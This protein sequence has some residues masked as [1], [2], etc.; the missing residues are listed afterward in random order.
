MLGFGAAGYIAKKAEDDPKFSAA[1]EDLDQL[2]SRKQSYLDDIASMAGGGAAAIGLGK[3][4]AKKLP[5]KLA[6]LY[7]PASAAGGGAAYEVFHSKEGEELESA[8]EGAGYGLAGYGAFAGLGKGIGA[9]TKKKSIDDILDEAD[10]QPSKLS[11]S[12]DRGLGAISTRLGNISPDLKF[13]LREF[14][15]ASAIKA[16]D[17]N[18]QV[19]PF[20]QGVKKIPSEVKLRFDQHLFNGDFEEASKILRKVDA[21]AETAFR[22]RV[23]P[24]L[25]DLGDKL[26][27]AGHTFEKLDN[28]FPRI[29]KDYDEFRKSIGAEQRGVITKELADYAAKKKISISDITP[30]E[31]TQIINMTLR[32]YQQVPGSKLRFVKKREVKQIGDD[33]MD[34][35]ISPEESLLRYIKGSV[36]DLEKRRFFG[37]SS[38]TD[39]DGMFDTSGSIGQLVDEAMMRGRI[40]PGRER[41]VKDMLEARFMGEFGAPN[42]FFNTVR[43]LGYMGT[44][45]NPVSTITQFGD[46]G[47]SASL[48]GFRN[49][50]GSMFGTKELKTVDLG[51][52]DLVSKEFGSG[53]MRKTAKLLDN[54]MSKAGFKWVDRLGKETYLNASLKK[55][56]AMAKT[57]TGQAKLLREIEPMLGENSEKFIRDLQNGEVTEDIKLWA[58]NQL[59]DIQPI[60]LSEM[61]EMYLRAKNGR[62]LYMLKSFTLKQFDVVRR[63]VIQEWKKGN[64]VDAAKQAALLAGYVSATNVTTQT[65]KDLILG[66]DVR[67]EDIPDKALWSLLGAY[68]MNEYVFDKY[69]KQGK[70]V[71]GAAGYVTP[72]TPIID[73]AL[74]LATELP[75]DDPKLEGILRGIPFVGP[76]VYNWFGGGAEKYNEKLRKESGVSRGRER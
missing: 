61:P 13:R 22:E 72:A 30:E 48:K 74:T 64:K 55:A 25:D 41:E 58:F 59:A 26:K 7:E 63:E 12:I 68:G 45:A 16:A 71:E 2:I 19:E 11:K 10:K 57:P 40:P 67:P 24:I 37:I 66:R 33:L 69:I 39:E 62:L 34:Q 60:A 3:A 5:G 1:V 70:L 42:K 23:V 15:Q 54:L 51:I 18:R 65:V 47:I 56:R 36:H 50:I 38:K 20:L 6:P 52:D 44:I 76:F 32:G 29:V 73:A 4:A 31:A 8:L 49:T 75:K 35:Y 46:I 28:Y 21:N 9:V 43:D 27:E 14:E 53:D 17:L